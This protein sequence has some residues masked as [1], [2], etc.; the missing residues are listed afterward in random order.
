MYCQKRRYEKKEI[1]N[2]SDANGKEE[3]TWKGKIAGGEAEE[4][5]EMKI[6]LPKV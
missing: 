3:A 5:L 4:E 1:R 2:K 6:C